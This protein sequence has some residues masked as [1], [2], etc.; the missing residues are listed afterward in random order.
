MGDS[1]S[2]PP[3]YVGGTRRRAAGT[4]GSAP[5]GDAGLGPGRVA[6]LVYRNWLKLVYIGKKSDIACELVSDAKY[7]L[8]WLFFK[9]GTVAVTCGIVPVLWR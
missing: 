7:W 5:P 8:N 6:Q 4:T 1:T 9:Y 2:P 3:E